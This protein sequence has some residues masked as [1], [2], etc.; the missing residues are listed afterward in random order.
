MQDPENPTTEHV[1]TLEVKALREVQDII[2]QNGIPAAITYAEENS[3][4]SRL[5]E[6]IAEV[7]LD[8][9]DFET[10]KLAF[11]RCKDYQGIQFIKRI[12]KFDNPAMK[13]AEIAAFFQ[14]PEKAEKI[15]LDIDRKDLAIDL[16]I[17]MGDWFR[18]V[19][20]IKT[21]G[22]GDDHLL[23]QAWNHIGDHYYDRQR[24]YISI[25]QESSD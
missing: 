2:E 18:V 23:E 1:K 17:R 24:W 4:Y 8:K 3:H 10:A 12:K 15:Y 11:V 13:K 14:N 9:L 21:G 19:Q 5:W 25:N 22:G 16:R 7:S 20:L 6:V